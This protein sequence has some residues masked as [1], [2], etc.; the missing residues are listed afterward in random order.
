MYL[1][2]L[3]LNKVKINKKVKMKHLVTVRVCEKI[4]IHLSRPENLSILT[5]HFLGNADIDIDWLFSSKH[6]THLHIS[7]F[8][9]HIKMKTKR[10]FGLSL[11]LANNKYEISIMPIC[12][13]FEWEDPIKDLFFFDRNCFRVLIISLKC[14]SLKT[15][16]SVQ[17]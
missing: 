13:S 5:C 16:S 1:I 4:D 8:H 12:S 3:T 11:I 15:V 10:L 14:L 17:T 2:I 6:Q 7:T 9:L